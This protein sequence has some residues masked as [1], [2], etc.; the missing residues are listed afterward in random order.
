MG[1]LRCYTIMEELFCRGIMED[2]SYLID[3]SEF[4][5]VWHTNLGDEF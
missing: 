5:R 1:I 2:I 3:Y 4:Y